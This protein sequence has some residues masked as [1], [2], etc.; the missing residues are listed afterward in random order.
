MRKHISFSIMLH[1]SPSISRK[2]QVQRY[3]YY[4]EPENF[5]PTERTP[6]LLMPELID[7]KVN[8]SDW[9]LKLIG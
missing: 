4:P 8:I 1:D 9:S 6:R 5:N 3:T 2:L 7:G